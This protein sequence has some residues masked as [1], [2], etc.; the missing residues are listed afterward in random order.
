MGFN[1]AFKGLKATVK[2]TKFCE[3]VHCVIEL[4]PSGLWTKSESS[5]KVSFA[6]S[7]VVQILGYAGVG[8]CNIQESAQRLLWIYP[9]WKILES[10]T[11]LDGTR[12]FF[13]F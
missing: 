13:S 8:M 11:T 5:V 3:L 1:S 10:G 7:R 9:F 4:F 6:Y 12:L 2:I